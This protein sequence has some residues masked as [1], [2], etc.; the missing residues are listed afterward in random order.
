MLTFFNR[1]QLKN[2]NEV[3]APADALPSGSFSGNFK[4]VSDEQPLNMLS[5][6]VTFEISHPEMSRD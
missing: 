2:I 5:I 3:F 6:L 4:L 1:E